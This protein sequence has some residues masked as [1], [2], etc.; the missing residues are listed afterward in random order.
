MCL[1]VLLASLSAFSFSLK[2]ELKKGQ[3]K[4]IEPSGLKSEANA[5]SP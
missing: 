1:P 5:D 2:V 3:Y 4:K